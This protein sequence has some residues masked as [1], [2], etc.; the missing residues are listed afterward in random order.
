MSMIRKPVGF[1]KSLFFMN[2]VRKMRKAIILYLQEEGIE[3]H[4]D[5]GDLVF[6]YNDCSLTVEIEESDDSDYMELTILYTL[7]DEKYESLAL[8]DKTL[9]AAQTNNETENHAVAFAYNDNLVIKSSYYFTSK[10][11]LLELFRVHL[12]DVLETLDKMKELSIKIMERTQ[13]R[14]RRIGFFMEPDYKEKH[15]DAA[16]QIAAKS[17][18]F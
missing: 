17:K 4:V 16:E 5:E 1:W 6:I 8:S 12:Y 11:M 10:R 15:E 3:C 13:P 18:S 7:D 9:I 2:D 14:K